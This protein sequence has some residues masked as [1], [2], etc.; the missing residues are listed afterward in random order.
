[1]QK[2]RIIDMKLDEKNMFRQII[3]AILNEIELIDL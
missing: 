1:M 2:T 3:L